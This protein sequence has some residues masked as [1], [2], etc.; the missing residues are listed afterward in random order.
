MKFPFSSRHLS[1]YLPLLISILIGGGLSIF[2]ALIH[3]SS[4]IDRF[5]K[6]FEK[7][8]NY[9]VE[10]LQKQIQEYTNITNT[11]GAF[12][13]ASDLVTRQDFQVFTQNFLNEYSEILGIA[14]VPK[15]SQQERFF[16]EKKMK[17]SGFSNF[18]IWAKNGSNLDNRT[19][20]FPVTYGEPK[21]NYE[22]VIGLD[23]SSDEVLN[24][25]LEKARDTGEIT[26][27]Q[28]IALINGEQGFMLYYPVYRR[29]SYPK[30][31]QERRQEFKGIVYTVYQIEDVIKTILNNSSFLNHTFYISNT[32][33]LQDNSVFIN[34]DAKTKQTSTTKAILFP[35]PLSCRKILPCQHEVMIADHQWFITIIPQFNKKNM[36]IKSTF[37]FFLGLGLTTLITN[38][39]WKTL[40]EKNHIEKV[41]AERTN[42]LMKT[43]EELENIVKQRTKELE[44][45][46]EEKNQILDKINHEL[47]VPLNNILGSL[48]VL[49]QNSSLTKKEQNS[50]K[51]I[52]ENSQYLLKLFNQILEFYKLT[53]EEI[54]IQ[55]NVVNL[56]NL[57]ISV[58]K[59][60][61]QQA[62]AKQVKLKY[63]IDSEVSQYIKLDENKLT[64]ILINLLDNAVKF[65]YK[66]VITIRLFCDNQAWLLDND[67]DYN[68]FKKNLWI[69]IEDH[70]NGI[71]IEIQKKVFKP[72]F[73][74]K[75]NKG[76]GLGL[77][78]TRKLISLMGGKIYLKS[79]LGRGTILQFHIPVTIPKPEEIHITSKS[80]KIVSIANDE[81]NYRILIVDDQIESR[82]L[83]I[84][85]LRPIGFNVKESTNQEDTLIIVNNW[86]PHL[87]FID[88]QMLLLQKNSDWM[89]IKCF[90]SLGKTIIIGVASGK[91]EN[92]QVDELQLYCDDCLYKP[93]AIELILEKINHY[94]GVNYYYEYEDIETIT[95]GT[96]VKNLNSSAL[97]MMSSQWLE[98]VYWAASSG[99]GRIL[100]DLIRHIPD[101]N[102]SV[103]LSMMELIDNF[104]YRE[105][106]QIIKPLINYDSKK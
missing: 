29:E 14:W 65:S 89:N 63:Y 93:F 106:I 17:T 91:I 68:S 86:H 8:G 76:V 31:I 32:K 21:K 51:M 82:E 18:I 27:S 73:R 98:Q 4:E 47:R 15:I 102:S 24:S 101:N 92:N 78:I 41:V 45:A 6:S 13:E 66:G 99:N 88:T 7:P 19:E 20:Y 72:F 23:L 74:W 104:N 2:I 5:K 44:K 53:S 71:P 59:Q 57:V 60:Y 26:S 9:L 77:S 87:I 37:V 79:Q 90:Q 100:Q 12:Y 33:K 22:S 49:T 11:L 36:I 96:I 52:H 67:I 85:F 42:A 94:L 61:D 40:S 28:P 30:N 35:I 55:Y 70:G 34:F 103:I 105:I 16:Y 43:T 1:L 56:K 64:K 62:K 81:P 69:E 75:E 84:N 3:W 46:N 80:K 10:H 50:F 54:S 25:P 39:L 97:E 38:Y 48:D 58:L 95:T 83:L